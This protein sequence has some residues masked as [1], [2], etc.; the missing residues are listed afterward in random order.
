MNLN[1]SVK[2]TDRITCS[3]STFYVRPFPTRLDIKGGSQIRLFTF[4]IPP[5]LERIVQGCGRFGK[6]R[7][8]KEEVWWGK[9]QKET[10]GGVVES[11]ESWRDWTDYPRVSPGKKRQRRTRLVTILGYVQILLV[12]SVWDDIQDLIRTWNGM[13]W[14]YRLLNVNEVSPKM[15]HYVD[16][17]VLS[18]RMV[19]VIVPEKKKFLKVSK[20]KSRLTKL[21]RITFGVEFPP[22][23]GLI[24]G[25]KYVCMWA[26]TRV[27]MCGHVGDMSKGCYV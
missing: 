6:F 17:R 8:P 19:R 11:G 22:L 12:W 2:H 20:F 7:G 14:P 5:R 21:G 16:I 10:R 25:S 24:F 4:F 9:L 27:R 23:P 13:E 26:C 18:G 15:T 3:V 1:R